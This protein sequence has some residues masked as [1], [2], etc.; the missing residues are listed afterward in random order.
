VTNLARH[1][2][3][4]HPSRL[5]ELLYKLLY[6]VGANNGLALGLIFQEPVDFRDGSVESNDG[7]A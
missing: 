1:D 7:E 4:H 2:K 6:R 5:L 3:H